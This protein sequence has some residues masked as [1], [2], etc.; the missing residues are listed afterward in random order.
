VAVATNPTLI[1]KHFIFGDKLGT[2][3]FIF[4]DSN[5]N[6]LYL[7][8]A[9]RR[10]NTDASWSACRDGSFRS[11]N[12]SFRSLGVASRDLNEACGPHIRE[13]I[14]VVAGNK[15]G[16]RHN[17]LVRSRDVNA[18]QAGDLLRRQS[19]LA[20]LACDR[21]LNPLIWGSTSREVAER[22]RQSSGSIKGFRILW[23]T[24]WNTVEDGFG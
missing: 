11:K 4:G 10:I 22:H 19:V 7:E 15:S 17:P 5:S 20:V 2:K 18:Y 16:G 14:D 6:T 21:C 12:A 8:I 23:R 3:H 1:T 24:I 9:N 13:A